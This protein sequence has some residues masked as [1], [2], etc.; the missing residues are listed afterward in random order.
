MADGPLI[1]QGDKTLLLEV[2]HQQ[3]NEARREI[4]PFAELERAPEHIHS[5]RLTALGLWNARAAGHT[6]AEVTATLTKYSRYP[7]PP[8]LLVDVAETM[9]R[10]GRLQLLN[11]P[12]H[13]LVLHASDRAV[14]I[15]TGRVAL[16]GPSQAFRADDAVR[17]AYLGY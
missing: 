17:R 9:D 2:A 4:A 13:G 10:Y 3:A 14:L 11:D 6:A 12:V 8:A 15:E 5:Y 7:I 1:I 16:T